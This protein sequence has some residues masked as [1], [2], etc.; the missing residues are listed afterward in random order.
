MLSG[1]TELEPESEEVVEDYETIRQRMVAAEAD[2]AGGPRD[3]M[4]ACR[5]GDLLRVK[6]LVEHEEVNVNQK[7][8]FDALPIYFCCLCGHQDVLEYLLEHGARLDDGTFEAHRCYYAALT[9]EIQQ[10]LREAKAKPNLGAM[11]HYA[12][13][14]RKWLCPTSFSREGDVASATGE[15]PSDADGHCHSDF[16]LQRPNLPD[17]PVHRCVLAARSAYFDKMFRTSWRGRSRKLLPRCTG[18]RGQA[19]GV[20]LEYLY[21]DSANFDLVLADDVQQLAEQCGLNRLAEE[22]KREVKLVMMHLRQIQGRSNHITRIMVKPGGET[23]GSLLRA[24]FSKLLPPLLD[25]QEHSETSVAPDQV[26]STTGGGG[27]SVRIGCYYSDVVFMVQGQ[28]GA[29]QQFHCHR[30]VLAARSEYFRALFGGDWSAGHSDGD[31]AVV[32]VPTAATGAQGVVP[33]TLQPWVFHA[34]LEHIYTDGTPTVLPTAKACAE[35]CAAV[36]PQVILGES[37]VQEYSGLSVADIDGKIHEVGN[38]SIADAA[39]DLEEVVEINAMVLDAASMFLDVGLRQLC[40]ATLV[41]CIQPCTATR[42]IEIGMLFSSARLLDAS[43]GQQ[44]QF[45]SLLVHCSCNDVPAALELHKC[46]MFASSHLSM[47]HLAFSDFVVDSLL[48]VA[49]PTRTAIIA[50]DCIRRAQ[51]QALECGMEIDSMQQLPAD[52]SAV[53]GASGVIRKDFA[54]WLDSPRNHEVALHLVRE[55]IERYTTG[56][57][58]D[59]LG[60]AAGPRRAESGITHAADLLGEDGVKQ[61]FGSQVRGAVIIIVPDLHSR[62]TAST[63]LVNHRTQRQLL[64]LLDEIMDAAQRQVQ[65]LPSV[66]LCK[67]SSIS[68]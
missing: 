61:T 50:A 35:L 11:D 20:V 65:L 49:L 31:N 3:L 30:P 59:V 60:A 13:Q 5:V 34:L 41:R 54:E 38:A 7:D 64:W 23:T 53:S 44:W 1:D 43:T 66:A 21:T 67:I 46:C 4:A 57:F 63:A 39:A 2:Q 32:A 42:C 18:K 15:Q 26:V 9:K 29:S 33:V 6:F 19:F 58:E 22:V 16:V 45:L 56:H 27:D 25:E 14:M 12:E 48:E 10:V 17:A 24:S 51:R 8:A 68:C 47:L 52:F 40:I 55:L 28:S 36:A 37:K 62:L